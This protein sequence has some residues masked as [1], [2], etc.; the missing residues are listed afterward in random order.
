MIAQFKNFKVLGITRDFNVCDCCGKEDLIKT[1]AILDVTYGVVSH[2]GTTCAASIDK[3]DT[4][5]AAKLAK[6]DIQAE[7]RRFD[8]RDKQAGISAYG[9][10]RRELKASGIIMDW[11]NS[12][13]FK[14]AVKFRK[15]EILA[16]WTADEERREFFKN[17]PEAWEKEMEK[18]RKAFEAI[19][20]KAA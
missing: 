6:K 18:T 9:T 16:K 4:L 19:R 14:T 20:N 15:E 17:N 5:E 11:D 2:F 3:Y 1:V 7:V 13:A 10:L 12:E 8:D